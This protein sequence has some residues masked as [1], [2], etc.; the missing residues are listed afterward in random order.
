MA[1]TKFVARSQIKKAVRSP[2]EARQVRRENAETLKESFSEFVNASIRCEDGVYRQMDTA[3]ISVEETEVSLESIHLF[4]T[5]FSELEEEN[6]SPE[7]YVLLD[8][9]EIMQDGKRRAKREGTKQAAQEAE[10]RILEL[11]Q[12][13]EEMS[14]HGS[15]K[16]PEIRWKQGP[17]PRD[18]YDRI[19]RKPGTLN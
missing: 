9:L 16:K 15:K 19:E 2:N 3:A 7:M 1:K 14:E 18:I 11:E 4:E 10:L 8:E 5:S 17:L 13:I 6:I 12:Q